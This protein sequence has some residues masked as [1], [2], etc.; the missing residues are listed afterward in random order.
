MWANVR[1]SLCGFVITAFSFCSTA[2]SILAPTTVTLL[3]KDK[4]LGGIVAELSKRVGMT[5]TADPVLTKS[6]CTIEVNGQ[7][8]WDSLETLATNCNAK[9]VLSD[10]GRKIALQPK[11]EGHFISSIHGPFRLVASQVVGKTLLEYGTTS[12]E[13]YLNLHWEPRYPVYRVAAS[14][15]ITKAFDDRGRPLEAKS[16]I[17]WVQPDGAKTELKL[18]IHGLTAESKQIAV[19]AG[20]YRVTASA[21][22]L[23]FRFD[24]LQT[25]LPIVQSQEKVG[26]SLKRIVSDEDSWIFELELL[27]PI[28]QPIFE[29]FEAEVWLRDNRPRLISPDASKTYEATGYEYSI[30]EEKGGGRKVIAKY[31]FPGAASP[32]AKGWSLIYE[33]PAPL[34]EFDVPF[35]LKNL[36]IP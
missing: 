30:L 34:I 4:P 6:K 9:I 15:R 20:T 26:V 32:L 3:E 2:D 14:P 5:I 18:S 31:S 1:L 24:S 35:E 21:K 23:A 22:I 33:T 28:G 17:A 7:S 11:G 10:G 16:T 27:Y 13:V 36:P 25:S 19:L 8:L 12:H 29:S